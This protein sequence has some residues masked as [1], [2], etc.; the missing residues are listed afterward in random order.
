MTGSIFLAAKTSAMPVSRLATGKSCI[1]STV[2]GP[3]IYVVRVD[4]PEHSYTE[5]AIKK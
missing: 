3:G 4:T 2:V 1:A 5:K